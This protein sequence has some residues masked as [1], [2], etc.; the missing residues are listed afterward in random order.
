MYLV[1]FMV[2]ENIDFGQKV[3]FYYTPETV[4]PRCI[5]VAVITMFLALILTFIV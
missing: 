2:I 5:G 1:H 3:D 4:I